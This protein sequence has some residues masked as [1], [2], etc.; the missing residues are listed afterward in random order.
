MTADQVRA[1]LTEWYPGLRYQFAYAEHTY[2]Y[3]PQDVLK[4]GVYFCTVKERDGP[5]DKLSKLDREGVYRLSLGIGKVAYTNR[6]GPPPAR[7]PKGVQPSRRY[8]KNTTHAS[9]GNAGS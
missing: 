3:N 6:F 9:G 4:Q 1:H 2:F 8:G 5:K 7:P